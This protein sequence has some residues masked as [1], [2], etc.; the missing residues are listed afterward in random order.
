MSNTKKLEA[1][2]G[3]AAEKVSLRRVI[4]AEAADAG[5]SAK[6]KNMYPGLGFGTAYKILQRTYKFT[7][8]P[9]LKGHLDR[10]YGDNFRSVFGTKLGEDMLHSTSG[11][12]V[13]LGEIV[14]LPLDMLKVKAQTNPAALSGRGVTEIF[15]AEGFG[16]Y[17]GW[18]WTAARNMPG[19]FALFGA[20]SCVYSWIFGLNPGDKK[21]WGQTTCASLMGGVASI[22]VSSPMDVIKTRIQNKPF[23]DPRSGAQVLGSLFR[24]EGAGALFKGLVPKVGLIG[25][26]LVFSWTVAQLVA[27]KLKENWPGGHLKQA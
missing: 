4:F 26:K 2:G 16:L 24:N 12:L 19:S 10:K 3:Q 17:R 8:Q 5:F 6:L 9:V 15:R 14:L 21:T 20:T 23:D 18:N 25:P 27:A 22:A 7:A 1:A 11:A 13:G